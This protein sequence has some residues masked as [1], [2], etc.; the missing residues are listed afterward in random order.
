M[1]KSTLALAISLGVI[2]QQAGAAGFIE[3]SKANLGLRNFYFDR[4]D[5]D[6][7]N[8]N[9]EASEWGQGFIFNYQSGF[10]E[11]TVGVGVDVIGLAGIKLDSGGDSSIPRS[12][13]PGALFPQESDG[14]AVDSYG[15]AGA[16]L[17]LRL[18]KTEARIG[19]LQ[20]K[21][22]VVNINDGRLLPQLFEGGQVTSNEI[23][24]LTLT[25]GQ[26]EHTKTRSSSDSIG[27]RIGVPNNT[28]FAD[29]NKFYFAGGDY[30]LSKDLTAQYYYGN[31]KDF[32]KQHFLG[33]VHNLVLPAGSLKTDLRY[34]DSSSDGKN[35]SVAGRAEG[36]SSNGYYAGS[37]SPGEVDNRTWSALFTYSLSGHS[38]GL[39]YQQ[40]S[41]DSA[42]PFLSQGDG[43]TAYLITDRQ[44]NKF[45][46]AGERTWLAEYGYDFASLGVPGL[47]AS[48][49]YLSGTDI[50][51]AQS[52]RKEW[53][54][55]FR[56]DYTLQDGALK[57]LGFSWRNA[58]FRSNASTSQDENRLIV[59]YS[60]PLL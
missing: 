43:A 7:A 39:G 42:F 28:P 26:L 54:R 45:L 59:S 21:L 20:P 37:A 46:S 57:G 25:A 4:N 34:F 55:D 17:K 52:D 32:Y 47:K 13:A 27:L 10:T 40:V 60:I 6:T 44:I 30:K 22:P 38:L 1:N 8:S 14:S 33:L 15:K 49:A 53:E 36:Y 50:D 51:A 24:N 2:A 58:S 3:D 5:K 9:S 18:S 29:S 23:D 56:V 41:G 11:G 31:L 16:T 19:T 12:R 35:G 48:V